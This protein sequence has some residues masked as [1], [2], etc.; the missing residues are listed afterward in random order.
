[1]KLRLNGNAIRLRLS[2]TDVA[3]LALEGLLEEQLKFSNDTALLYRLL[4][5]EEIRK[6]AI[7]Y[8]ENIITVTIPQDFTNDWPHNKVTGTS[9]THTTVD[10]NEIFILIEKDFKCL[11]NTEEDQS[12][13]F[14]NPK[15]MK[16]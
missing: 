7:S 6:P 11:D 15:L 9:A 10:G 5:K 4:A 1:M 13:N 16:L 3:K 12:D 2:Q 14:A 8:A